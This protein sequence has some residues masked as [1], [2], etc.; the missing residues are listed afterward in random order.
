MKPFSNGAK[1]QVSLQCIGGKS[2]WSHHCTVVFLDSLIVKDIWVQ[3]HWKYDRPCSKQTTRRTV[4]TCVC[5]LSRCA[6]LCSSGS[7]R[8][9]WKDVAWLAGQ[10]W[11]VDNKVAKPGRLS[12]FSISKEGCFAWVHKTLLYDV[13]LFVFSL[14]STNWC[15]SH[16]LTHIEFYTQTDMHASTHPGTHT[17]RHKGIIGN[18]T[19]RHSIASSESSLSLTKGFV[20]QKYLIYHFVRHGSRWCVSMLPTKGMIKRDPT[21]DS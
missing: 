7:Q 3:T 2:P 11:C 19:E 1:R 6:L 9:F 18:W 5:I 13:R 16:I 14:L 10:F 4:K 17:H 21:T 20:F 12:L 8:L 15:T